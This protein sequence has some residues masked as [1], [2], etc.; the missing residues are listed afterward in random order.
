[1]K[2]PREDRKLQKDLLFWLGKR[3]SQIAAGKIKLETEPKVSLGLEGIN[4]EFD[5][6][7]FMRKDL[8]ESYIKGYFATLQKEVEVRTDKLLLIKLA[9]KIVN[10]KLIISR[11]ALE[12]FEKEK[13][14]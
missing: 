12:L 2:K 3:C 4:V 5:T 11:K 1:M 13:A 14:Y 9:Q 10:T 8:L 7:P 6:E